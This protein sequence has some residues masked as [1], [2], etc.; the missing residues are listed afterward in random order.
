MTRTPLNVTQLMF[1]K[2]IPHNNMKLNHSE[3]VFVSALHAL[4]ADIMLLACGNFDLRAISLNSS[5]VY[6]HFVAFRDVS[7]MAFDELT[8][9]LLL[10]V[11]E[12][13]PGHWHLVSLLLN[14]SV[15]IEVQRVEME[16]EMFYPF[17]EVCDSLVLIGSG[18][19]NG[20]LHIYNVSAELQ[21]T[22]STLRALY[23]FGSRI[24]DGSRALASVMTCFSH[25]RIPTGIRSLCISS[26]GHRN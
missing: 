25:S 10:L 9:T 5:Q 15:W 16:N 13:K 24:L 1:V 19:I 4:S 22:L 14:G 17:I 2:R 7:R 12:T 11:C 8:N 3:S 6:R 26:C 18:K 21:I 20:I 23:I